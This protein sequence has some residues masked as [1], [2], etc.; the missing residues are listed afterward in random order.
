M[1]ERDQ[2][3]SPKSWSVREI[4][5]RKENHRD[6]WKLLSWTSHGIKCL[7]AKPDHL[8]L[9]KH[10]LKKLI[11]QTAGTESSECERKEWKRKNK[12]KRKGWCRQKNTANISVKPQTENSIFSFH[13][14]FVASVV[15]QP[16]QNSSFQ[17]SKTIWYGNKKFDIR[18]T[19]VL[20]A[21]HLKYSHGGSSSFSF[22]LHRCRLKMHKTNCSDWI[23]QEKSAHFSSVFWPK[24]DK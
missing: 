2:L 15:H 10:K 14:V 5:S 22:Y 7:V 23:Y 12:E 11:T 9:M 6:P 16:V 19:S 24:M 13:L 20:H 4:L 8:E 18:A 17:Q 21:K 3:D 1:G